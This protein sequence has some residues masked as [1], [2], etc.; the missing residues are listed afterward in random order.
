PRLAGIW[1]VT[2]WTE[3]GTV[4]KYDPPATLQFAN[5]RV[6][7][8]G[9]G[10]TM[11]FALR[12]VPKGAMGDLL[13]LS[14]PNQ[15]GMQEV[16]IEGGGLVKTKDGVMTLCLLMASDKPRD[17]PKEFAAPK[18][19]GY[20][21][22]ELKRVS[23]KELKLSPDPLRELLLKHGYYALSLDRES[24]GLRIA[25]ARIGEHELRLM[26]DTGASWSGFDAAGL[27]KW[28]AVRL[29]KI[30][31]NAGLG[32]VTGEEMNLRGLKLGGFDIR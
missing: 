6:K 18:G 32:S 7:M 1:E 10:V 9:D 17:L 13:I 14:N 5:Q 11:E 28:G 23:P 3:D 21:L 27:N 26:V 19:S 24:N 22:L 25:N 30:E 16:G 4:L 31:T 15:E 12:F 29:G 20:S 2:R 8:N